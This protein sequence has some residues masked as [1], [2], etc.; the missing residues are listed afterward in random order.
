MMHISY[1]IYISQGEDDE[2]G[3]SMYEVDCCLK[4]DKPSKWAISCEREFCM[5]RARMFTVQSEIDQEQAKQCEQLIDYFG[6]YNMKLYKE[7]E[8]DIF[9]QQAVIM[10]IRIVI[11]E[12]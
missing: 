5:L 12:H 3:T 2:Y 4:I 10:Y 6:I 1:L 8:L 11:S 9:I 7:G